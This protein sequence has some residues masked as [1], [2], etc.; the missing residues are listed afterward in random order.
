MF[1]KSAAA[2]RLLARLIIDYALPPR[3]PGCGVIVADDRQFCTPCWQ[4]LWFLEGPA[5]SSCS[6]PFPDRLPSADIYCGAC[7]AEKPPFSGAPAALAYGPAAR[8]IALKLKY[9][10]R[11]GH[12]RLMADMMARPLERLRS[13]LPRSDL[14]RSDLPR[15]TQRPT[16]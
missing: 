2:L 5:C 1:Q 12:A 11:L 7:L 10:R 4:E 9:G 14:P 3:C 13:D 16:T 8:T 15:T 6:L